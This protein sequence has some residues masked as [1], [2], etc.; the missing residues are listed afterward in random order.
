MRES[1]G[2]G[3]YVSAVT[4]MRSAPRVRVRTDSSKRTQACPDFHP[5]IRRCAFARPG[6]QRARIKNSAECKISLGSRNCR[7]RRARAKRTHRAADDRNA[8]RIRIFMGE[9]DQWSHAAVAV[10]AGAAPDAGDELVAVRTKSIRSD[11][12]LLHVEA[13]SLDH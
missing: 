13:V 1:I 3:P 2:G 4:P 5:S 11:A 6:A 9:L 8:F 10:A 7:A 12:A